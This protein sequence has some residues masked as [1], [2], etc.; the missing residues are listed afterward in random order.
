LALS[1]P[2][3][4]RSG[5]KTFPK[6]SRRRSATQVE[7][8]RP[9][10]AH[11]GTLADGTK[12]PYYLHPKLGWLV[13]GD[14]PDRVLVRWQYMKDARWEDRDSE[15]RRLAD[16]T[17]RETELG[18]VENTN[19]LSRRDRWRA[20]MPTLPESV[21]KGLPLSRPQQGGG[22]A[23]VGEVVTVTDSDGTRWLGRSFAAAGST[24]HGFDP[25]GRFFVFV[26]PGYRL[27]LD[28]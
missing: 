6:R 3:A 17:W 12:L 20:P 28:R 21:A 18:K 24:C 23:Y 11:Q 26:G 9:V 15:W 10:T 1:D 19:E 16:G 5:P 13:A 27:I 2:P 8:V 7:T 25:T 4:P 14:D 22:H